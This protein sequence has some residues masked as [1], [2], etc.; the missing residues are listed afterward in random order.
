M[1][2]IKPG[3]ILAEDDLPP[4]D[5]WLQSID[6]ILLLGGGVPLSPTEPPIYVQ[7]RCDVVAELMA[8]MHQHPS[9]VCLSAGTAHVPQYIT[10]HNG[11]PLWESAA[12]AAYLMQHDKYPVPAAQVYAET[13]SYDTISNAFYSRTTMTD[14]AGWRKILVVT[15]EFHMQRSK[16][17]FDWIFHVPAAIEPASEA[18]Y[19]LYYLSCNNVGLSKEALDLRK[20]H[21]ARGEA[22]VHKLAGEYTT[23]KGV[24]EFL[25]TKH[26]FYAAEKLVRRGMGETTGS[27][28]DNLLKVSYGKSAH[29]A[30]KAVQYHDG[31]VILSLSLCFVAAAL[32][33]VLVTE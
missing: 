32:F 20:S 8:R 24:W 11:L 25:T 27:S 30:M 18:P 23:L 9:V 19:E 17:I 21:E 33:V 6:A 29:K 1:V 31:R 4:H 14:V 15:N 10:Q 22:S 16:A 28:S 26:D 2:A 7:R 5:A 3:E 13:T 12:S